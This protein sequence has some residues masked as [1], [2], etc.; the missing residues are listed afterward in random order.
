MSLEVKNTSIEGLILI[1]PNRYEDDRGYL[2][3]TFSNRDF[4]FVVGEQID[5]VQDNESLSSKGVIRGLHFQNPPHAM[6]KLVRVVSGSI[7]D[8]AVDLRAGSPTYGKHEKVLLNEENGWQFWIPAGFAHG[9]SALEDGTK[10]SYKCTEFYAPDS[11]QSLKW[12]DKD[13][14]ID[15]GVENPQISTKDLGAESFS[16]FESPFVENK[17]KKHLY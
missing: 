3:E 2:S 9:F 17:L 1:R 5:F 11:E 10:V 14:S 4:A 15:W 6:G 8:V 12:D 16:D 13:L 7:F